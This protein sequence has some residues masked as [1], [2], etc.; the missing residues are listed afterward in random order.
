MPPKRRPGVPPVKRKS[1]RG[2]VQ[3]NDTPV[4]RSRSVSAATRGRRTNNPTNSGKRTSSATNH[5][6][7]PAK[8]TR[9]KQANTD[10]GTSSQSSLTEGDISRI[11]EAV[12]QQV[13]EMSTE[14]DTANNPQD[15]T[16]KNYNEAESSETEVSGKS[17]I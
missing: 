15:A 10:D 17:A 16:D 9:Q 5:D 8:R 11:A 13:R 2:R 1:D 4:T 12:L 14:Q 6:A 3:R 7:P